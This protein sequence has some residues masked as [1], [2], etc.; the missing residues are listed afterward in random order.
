CG[1][2]LLKVIIETGELKNSDLIERLSLALLE[3]GADFIKTSTGKAPLGATVEAAT[4]ILK[5]LSAYQ[6]QRGLLKGLKVSGGVKTLEQAQIFMDL[7]A[8]FFGL[9]YL[10]PYTFRIG[11]SSL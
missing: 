7:A 2:Y 1:R 6:R 4:A 11:A 9:S 5:A 3:A 10:Q 8:D